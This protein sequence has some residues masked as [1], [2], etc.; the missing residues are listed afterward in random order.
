MQA[1]CIWAITTT[2]LLGAVNI[3]LKLFYSAK[4]PP[5]CLRNSFIV[6]KHHPD[7][8]SCLHD[9]VEW[10]WFNG[11]HKGIDSVGGEIIFESQSSHFFLIVK[12]T[13]E[14]RSQLLCVIDAS[15]TRGVYSF[16][17]FAE[18]RQSTP[19]V[20]SVLLPM[21]TPRSLIHIK[22]TAVIDLYRANTEATAVRQQ[23]SKQQ[24][25]LVLWFDAKCFIN[26]NPRQII[27]GV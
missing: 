21:L 10:L 17:I 1:T 25:F 27:R 23:L 11:E 5:W 15:P 8:S 13:E 2:L 7:S 3:E 12:N 19:N 18:P 14:I 22:D 6:V 20:R 26:H 16:C 4:E 24:A 9:S